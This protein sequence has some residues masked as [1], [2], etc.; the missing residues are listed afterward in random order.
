[1]HA[2]ALACFDAKKKIVKT[3]ME[4]EDVLFNDNLNSSLI[5]LFLKKCVL[6]LFY[7]FKCNTNWTAHSHNADCRIEVSHCVRV[8]ERCGARVR[9]R[10]GWPSRSRLGGDCDLS[11]DPSLVERSRVHCGRC[12]KVSI[13]PFRLCFTHLLWALFVCCSVISFQRI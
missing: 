4:L 10:K 1:M 5:V 8:Q 7:I 2:Y 12:R 6:L 13:Q 11:H 3:D 9:S